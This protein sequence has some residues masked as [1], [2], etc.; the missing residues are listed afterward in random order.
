MVIRRLQKRIHIAKYIVLK[1]NDIV[2]ATELMKNMNR[3][4]Q[5]KQS[6]DMLFLQNL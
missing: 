5:K 1:S 6:S 3:N 2:K 4:E